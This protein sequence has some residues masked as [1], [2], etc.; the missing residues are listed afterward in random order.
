MGN[1]AASKYLSLALHQ[2][3]RTLMH[4]LDNAT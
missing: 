1:C 3:N 2:A 4:Q